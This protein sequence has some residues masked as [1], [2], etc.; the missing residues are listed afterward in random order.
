METG[1]QDVNQTR[2]A[3]SAVVRALYDDASV[4]IA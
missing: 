4:T 1:N 3:V 2:A